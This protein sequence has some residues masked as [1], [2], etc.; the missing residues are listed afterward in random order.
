MTFCFLHTIFYAV[1][2]RGIFLQTFWHNKEHL[3]FIG[4]FVLYVREY[5]LLAGGEQLFTDKYHTPSKDIAAR[6]TV[7]HSSWDWLQP[8]DSLN[9]I[10]IKLLWILS[11]INWLKCHCLVDA[12]TRASCEMFFRST[13]FMLSKTCVWKVERRLHRTGLVYRAV[14]PCCNQQLHKCTHGWQ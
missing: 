1:L 8:V 3:V 5:Q 10:L 2:L 7:W 12:Y 11:S 14:T 4:L 9:C 6:P 13:F